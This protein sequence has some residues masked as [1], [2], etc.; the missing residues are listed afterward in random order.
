MAF[1]VPA[2]S[3]LS[4]RA[5]AK[6]KRSEEIVCK[7]AGEETLLYDPS[8]DSIHIL[9]PTAL[10]VWQLCDGRHSPAEIE[11]ILRDRFAGTARR[12]VA[13]DVTSTLALLETEGL[14]TTLS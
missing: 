5:Q 3:G 9:N 7:S 6:P 10:L 1:N 12:D 11:V 2:S 8:T 13:A 14:T 4:D